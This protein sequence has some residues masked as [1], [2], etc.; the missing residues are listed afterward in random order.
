MPIFV[1][2][3]DRRMFMAFLAQSVHRRRWICLAYCLM[4]NH[5]HV[6]I[7]LTGPNLSIG[8]QRLNWLYA[9][10]FNERYGHV[11]HLFESRFHSQ[12]IETTEHLLSALA[13][14]VLNPV[15]AGLC[16]DPADWE[17]SSFRSTAG[18]ERCPRF[19][20]AAHV[21]ELFGRGAR[22][23]DLYAAHVRDLA[24]LLTAR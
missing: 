6:V 7:K 23:A 11:G 1:D 14:V 3:D 17:W 22:G 15:R 16:A 13:Y 8:M 21:R 5:Y 24:E 4:A 12:T 18:L 9:L 19:L 20:A 2:D 10:R